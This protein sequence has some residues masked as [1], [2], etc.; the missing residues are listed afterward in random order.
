MPQ[1][2]GE[3]LCT[4]HYH[5]HPWEYKARGLSPPANILS[6]A[7]PQPQYI[8]YHSQLLSGY[9]DSLMS[10]ASPGVRESRWACTKSVS[11]ESGKLWPK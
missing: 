11:V 6:D 10:L 9:A 3:L 2:T 4:C 5:Q 1:G 8:P 7:R